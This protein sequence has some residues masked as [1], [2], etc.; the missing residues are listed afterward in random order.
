[1][2]REALRKEILAYLQM[3]VI[4]DRILTAAE[5]G[6]ETG[7]GKLQTE[8][9]QAAI[10]RLSGQGGGRLSLPAGVYR[11][12]ALRLKSGV[13]LHLAAQ[14]TILSFTAEEPEKNYPLVRVHWEGSPCYNF[15]SL[16][17]AEGASD[18]AVTG[19]GILDG[20]ADGEHWWNWHHQ[21]EESWSENRWDLQLE[22][23]KTLRKMNLE[24]LPVEKRVFGPG[25]FLRPNFVQFLNC[26]R[27]LLSGITLKNSPMWQLNPVFCKSVIFDG[28]T[29]SGHGCNNDGCDP[30]SCDG[31][32]I[33]NC[34]FDTGDD[35]ISLKSGRDRDGL[36]SNTPC[37]HVLIEENLFLDGHGGIALGSEMSGGIHTVLAAGNRFVSPHLTYALRFKTNAKRGG[38]V[39]NI[40]LCDSVMEHVSGAAIHGTMLY[41]DGRAGDQL[42]VFCNIAMEHV[43]AFGGDY[44]IFL[45]AFPE[46]PITGLELRHIT[47]TGAEQELRSMNWKDAVME[48]V[49]INGKSYPRPGKVRILGI[50]AAGKI[51]QAFAEECGGD[52]VL[53][54]FWEYSADGH[55]WE[56]LPA[57]KETVPSGAGRRGAEDRIQLKEQK[58]F[59]RV[60]AQDSMGNRETSQVYRILQGEESERFGEAGA[61]LLCRGLADASDLEDPDRLLTRSKAAKLLAKLGRKAAKSG[62]PSDSAMSWD[63]IAAANAFFPLDAAG[64]IFPDRTVTREEMAT[65]LMQACGVNYRNASTTMPVCKDVS[66]V[67]DPYGTNAARA[68][69]FEFMKLEEGYFYPHREVTRREAAEMITRVADFAGI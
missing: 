61:R 45:E 66:E 30:E 53:S 46:V 56:A 41:E 21:V 20:G 32:W 34:T 54:F 2:E 43:T 28:V 31:V 49:T 40:M 39:E 35:C 57:G 52:G 15:S 65:V 7:S 17:Y 42:P 8:K 14:D 55:S 4:P 48:D 63:G 37:C 51:L 19:Q 47:I 33:K 5:A 67:A 3:P 68:L 9:L 11:T 26:E 50:P 69:Y 25:H 62:I 10:D 18:I 29:L 13:E 44:G 16:L 22:D 1:M 6:I 12:G 23:R 59:L 38:R 36:V 60:T 58:G 27:V 64:R 24:G